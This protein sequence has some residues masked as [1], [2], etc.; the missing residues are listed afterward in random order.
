MA[1][2]PI[3]FGVAPKF[4]LSSNKRSSKPLS[5]PQTLLPS[6]AKYSFATSQH[7]S[8][9]ESDEDKNKCLQVSGLDASN[10]GAILEA[11]GDDGGQK[12]AGRALAIPRLPN[13][14][15]RAETRKRKL[16]RAHVKVDKATQVDGS[17][18]A[19]ASPNAALE[20]EA[21]YGLHVA[22]VK[23]M[24]EGETKETH[25][26]LEIKTPLTEDEVALQ[27]LLGGN[28]NTNSNAII[29]APEDAAFKSDYASAPD[30]ATLD[31]YLSVPVEEFGAALLRG[32]GWKEGETPGRRRHQ[33]QGR[34]ETNKAKKPAT[35]LKER[36][37]ALLGIGAKEEEAVGV[38]LGA[39]GSARNAKDRTKKVKSRRP[40]DQ[41]YNPV[42]LRNKVT[43]EQLTETELKVKLEQQTITFE[44]RR[45]DHDDDDEVS[46]P[47]KEDRRDYDR[48]KYY[49][50]SKSK[51]RNRDRDDRDRDDR[52]RDDRDRDRDRERNR[53]RDRYRDRERERKGVKYREDNHTQD[54]KEE[55]RD[56]Y[57]NDH[58]NRR[59]DRFDRNQSYGDASRSKDWDRERNHRKEKYEDRHSYSNGDRIR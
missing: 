16:Q 3:K 30:V 56:K 45:R 50:R 28:A 12:E 42:T 54:D 26:P 10:G 20:K 35:E 37:A 23:H 14:D 59:Y 7:D 29:F 27:A 32:M 6:R 33:Q 24:S 2:E 57:Y 19:A 31:D 39:W 43:G 53:A 48:E 38:E 34:I 22:S 21:A 13:R 15:W 17:D 8:D 25:S 5:K 51:E 46:V 18:N 9:A 49:K 55:R 36:R 11:V 58:N 47:Q 41:V 1:T 4:N 44:K 40:V 52:G